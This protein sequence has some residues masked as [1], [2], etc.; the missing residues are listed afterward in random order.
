MQCY[1]VKEK[2]VNDLQFSEKGM[3][4]LVNGCAITLVSDRN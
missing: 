4:L 3:N 2:S 1:K